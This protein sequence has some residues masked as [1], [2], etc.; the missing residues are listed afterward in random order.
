MKNTN[1]PGSKL[2]DLV[3]AFKVYKVERYGNNWV[4]ILMPLNEFND[5]SLQRKINNFLSLGYKVELI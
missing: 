1:K 2:N 4:T 5:E 3:K